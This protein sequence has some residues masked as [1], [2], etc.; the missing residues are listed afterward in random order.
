[1]QDKRPHF[2]NSMMSSRSSCHRVAHPCKDAILQQWRAAPCSRSRLQARSLCTLHQSNGTSS[3]QRVPILLHL[4]HPQTIS[5]ASSHEVHNFYQK[6]HC[7]HTLSST[8]PIQSTSSTKSLDCNYAL[9]FNPSS[10][11]TKTPSCNIEFS[12]KPSSPQ[13]QSKP[14]ATKLSCNSCPVLNSNQS[15][16]QQISFSIH[17]VLNFNQSPSFQYTFSLSLSL[18]FGCVGSWNFRLL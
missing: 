8:P 14:I 5:D 6:A 3:M 15:P 11:S 18:F 4:H 17:P 16:L 7:N 13:F 2:L 9:S 10:I 12:F 1:M